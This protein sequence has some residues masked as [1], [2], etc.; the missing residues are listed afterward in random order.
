MA[1]RIPSEVKPIY[2][3]STSTTT[4]SSFS[5]STTTLTSETNS[6]PLKAFHQF[7]EQA[8]SY[9]SVEFDK[10]Y[11]KISSVFPRKHATNQR[12]YKVAK[13]RPIRRVE[14]RQ[15]DVSRLP[16]RYNNPVR[17]RAKDYIRIVDSKSNDNIHP[18]YAGKVMRNRKKSGLSPEPHHLTQ[19]TTN[20]VHPNRSLTEAFY[21]AQVVGDGLHKRCDDQIENMACLSENQQGNAVDEYKEKF[22]KME[23]ELAEVK[24]QL[25]EILAE[26]NSIFPTTGPPPISNAQN[27]PSAPPLPPPPPPPSSISKNPV[28]QVATDTSKTPQTQPPPLKHQPYK[29]ILKNLKHVKLKRTNAP[30]T[31]FRLSVS[32]CTSNKFWENGV[33]KEPLDDRIFGRN[34]M[35][36]HNL[37]RDTSQSHKLLKS[38]PPT[39]EMEDTPTIRTEASG[40][41]TSKNTE[42]L[43]SPKITKMPPPDAAVQLRQ[44]R[45]ASENSRRVSTLAEE[46]ERA[47][48]QLWK[49]TGV[50]NTRYSPLTLE[51]SITEKQDMDLVDLTY[52]SDFE[53]SEPE[54]MTDYNETEN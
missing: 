32:S 39:T 14:H 18:T 35:H 44:G 38:Y 52:A 10:L 50:Q 15:A 23:K 46:L 37:P 28:A 17:P 47:S 21:A 31:P 33:G 3:S 49:S 25:A 40:F 7:I 36:K 43:R 27:I 8:K 51:K 16:Q 20:Q 13:R 30:W 54:N 45:R 1:P 53:R 34:K 22:A 2:S 4:A 19:V 12:A 48:D 5:S 42:I 29:D 11:E 24:Q 41:S 9:A 6:G 26:R